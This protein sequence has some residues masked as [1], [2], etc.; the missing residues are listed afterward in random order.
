MRRLEADLDAGIVAIAFDARDHAFTK[1]RMTQRLADVVAAVAPGSGLA[2][3][4][5]T[6]RDARIG[7][8]HPAG[9]AVALVHGTVQTRA[10]VAAAVATAIATS[11]IAAT[12]VVAPATTIRPQAQTALGAGRGHFTQPFQRTLGQ[13]GQE[14]GLHVVAG[15][16]VQHPGLGQ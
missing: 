2:A 10:P 5:A 15:L 7:R 3:G 9:L 1:A 12:A 4:I 14:A 8:A 16:A 11:A 6:G 13:L